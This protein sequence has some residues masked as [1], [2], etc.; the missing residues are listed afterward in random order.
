MVVQESLAPAGDYQ[1][2]Y[3]GKA[4]MIGTVK[5]KELKIMT[6]ICFIL[7]DF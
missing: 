7:S 3:D 5:D 1:C 6:I 4:K 2:F